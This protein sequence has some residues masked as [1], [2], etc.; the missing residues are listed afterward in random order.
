MTFKVQGNLS[1]DLKFEIG[2]KVVCLEVNESEFSIQM[3]GGVRFT[4]PVHEKSG[5]KKAV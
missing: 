4:V 1:L 2:G 3:E 5:L